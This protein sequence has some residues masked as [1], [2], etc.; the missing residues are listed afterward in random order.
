MQEI[1]FD[2]KRQEGTARPQHTKGFAER[3]LLSGA[4][5]QVMQHQDGY[6]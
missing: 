3:V 4:C 6:G 5:R 1:V 2:F